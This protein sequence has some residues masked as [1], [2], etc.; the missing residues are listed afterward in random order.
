MSSQTRAQEQAKTYSEGTRSEGAQ[1]KR[2]DTVTVPS[3]HNLF[4]SLGDVPPHGGKGYVCCL[5]GGGG[6]LPWPRKPTAL[7]V[8]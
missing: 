6:A 3:F 8:R 1:T 5:V 2:V 4:T 7:R